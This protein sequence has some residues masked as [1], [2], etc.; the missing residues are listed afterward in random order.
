MGVEPKIGGF[1]PQNGWFISWKTLLKLMIWGYHYFWKH[2]YDLL[3]ASGS[4]CQERFGGQH[5]SDKVSPSTVFPI[6]FE[7]VRADSFLG[8]YSND[9]STTKV[10]SLIYHISNYLT[11]PLKLNMEPEN[12]PP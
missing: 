7:I 5:V 3:V 9:F 4:R 12:T 11:T 1:Y 10:I 2:P 6:K 8:A